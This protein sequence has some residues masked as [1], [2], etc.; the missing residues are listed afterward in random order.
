VVLGPF[1]AASQCIGRH[2]NRINRLRRY[3]ALD[4]KAEG[5]NDGADFFC[6]KQF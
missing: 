5:K 2:T 4:E 3:D 6:Q 1:S